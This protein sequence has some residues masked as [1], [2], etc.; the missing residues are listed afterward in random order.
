MRL[1]LFFDL[2]MDSFLERRS[3]SA[4]RKFLLHDGYL[5]LQKSVYT[6]LV[7][8]DQMAIAAV[9]RLKQNK[10]SHGLVQLLKVTERQYAGMECIAGNAM[11]HNE[12]NTIE[13]LLIL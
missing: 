7:T 1:I 9:S 12:I 2:P 6:K 4:F 8:N 3:Y 13:S 11:S 10:P 5:I